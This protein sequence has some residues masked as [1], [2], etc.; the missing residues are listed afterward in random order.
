MLGRLLT[1][2][3]LSVGL[4]GHAIAADLDQFDY[5]TP[6]PGSIAAANSWEASLYV[7]GWMTSLDGQTGIDGFSPIDIDIT[8][9]EFIENLEFYFGGFGE[10]RRGRFGIAA[11]LFYADT[12][13][14]IRLIGGTDLQVK[15]GGKLGI[16]TL[17]GEYRVW[18]Q[19]KSYLDVMAGARLWYFKDEIDIVIGN[20]EI[21]FAG[22]DYTWVDP[23]I[24]AKFRLQCDCR[25]YLS[26]WGMVG[27]FGASSKIDWDVFGGVG[28][29]LREHISVL[30]GYR[31]IGVDYEGD[32]LLFDVIQHGPMIGTLF[33]F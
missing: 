20:D 1:S 9:E 15:M 10:V 5:I 30:A 18:E 24:G 13:D 14:G 29:Q 17:M 26:G 7:Y 19:Q 33:E 28:Y 6:A 12:A 4:A 2:I 31:A 11:D 25:F 22:K 32:E 23:M 27:G 21:G 8:F 16:A 3:G